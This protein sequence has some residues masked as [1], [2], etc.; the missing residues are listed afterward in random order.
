MRA[1]RIRH[2]AGLDTIERGISDAL[3][4]GPGEI[5]VRIRAASLNFRDNLVASGVFPAKDGLIPLSD[6]AGEVVEAGDGV[7]GF[8]PG[9]AVISTFH[10]NWRGGHAERSELNNA[11]GG[12]ANGY[13]CDY[14]TRPVSHFT[15]APAGLTHAESATLTCAGV[16]AWRALV[17]DGRVMPGATVL[18]LGT[19]GVSLFALQFAKA[20]GATIIA[21]SSSAAKL[22]RLKS[23]GADHVINYRET[24][25]WGEAVLGLTGGLGADHVIEVGGPQTMP[26]SLIAARTGGHVAIIGAAAGF[27]ID[28]MPFAIVQAKRLRLQAVTVGSRRDQLDMVRAIEAH[29]IRPVIDRSFALEDLADAFRHLGSGGHFGKIVIDMSEH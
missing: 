13:A 20:A 22:D 23:L 19:G 5:R 11:P 28:T 24:E 18:V 1:M 9:D 6:G 10:P 21:T 14:A 8:A 17:T 15:R 26:Q 12:P 29:D 27:D 7:D 3:P 2:P 25:N 4:P 16:T